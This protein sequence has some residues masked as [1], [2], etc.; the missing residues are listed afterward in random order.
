[1]RKRSTCKSVSKNSKSWPSGLWRDSL[2]VRP[3]LGEHLGNHCDSRSMS[4]DDCGTPKSALGASS[5]RGL[6]GSLGTVPPFPQSLDN[7][8]KSSS[9]CPPSPCPSNVSG[10]GPAFSHRSPSAPLPSW[11]SSSDSCSVY[12]STLARR[13]PLERC[14][15]ARCSDPLQRRSRPLGES[16]QRR[17]GEL[18]FEAPSESPRSREF[19]SSREF[20]LAVRELSARRHQGRR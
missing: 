17:P 14:P 4:D 3:A 10:A 16:A 11:L 7:V 20:A 5:A 19:V 15:P 1:M 9:N 8:K 6:I 2:S 18:S 13:C 12:G